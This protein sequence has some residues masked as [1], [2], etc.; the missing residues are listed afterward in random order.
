[1]TTIGPSIVI[2]GEITADEDVTIEGTIHGHVT[3]REATLAVGSH[4]RLEADLRAA[5]VLIAGRLEGS[6]SATE[7]IELLA[8]ATVDGSLSAERVVIAD[9]ARFNGGIDMGKR[10]IAARM[11]QYKAEHAVTS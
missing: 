4:A 10:T 6:A 7:R 3:V 2:T 8:T 11:A 5:R 1:M 9:G